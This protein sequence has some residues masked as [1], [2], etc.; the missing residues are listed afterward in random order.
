MERKSVTDLINS[1]TGGRLV[2]RQIPGMLE[3]YDHVYLIFEGIWTY[4]ENG[5]VQTWRGR[6]NKWTSGVKAS[7]VV[8]FLHSLMVFG[9][10]KVLRTQGM[11]DTAQQVK[12]I[13]NWW[14]KSWDQHHSHQALISAPIGLDESMYGAKLNTVAKVA[15]QLPGIGIK[16]AR[17]VGDRF[18]SVTEMCHANCEE[19]M[20]IDGIGERTAGVAVAHLNNTVC[21]SVGD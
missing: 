13:Y 10:V 5:Y 4:D 9:G 7:A 1:M 14:Q 18:K 8:N 3:T 2:A 6:G 20:E 19:W 17:T 11:K 21:G 12:W 16:R 15:A